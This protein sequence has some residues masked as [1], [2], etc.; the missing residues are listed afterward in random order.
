MAEAGSEVPKSHAK[1]RTGSVAL[2]DHLCGFR[3]CSHTAHLAGAASS[4][5]RFP[6]T[7]GKP[8]GLSLALSLSKESVGSDSKILPEA[9]QTPK[10]PQGRGASTIPQVA[11][12]R[13]DGWSVKG[14]SGELRSTQP[15]GAERL[16][17][18]P[19]GF[20]LSRLGIRIPSASPTPGWSTTHVILCEN[21]PD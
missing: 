16:P 21:A 20:L 18:P 5:F 13:E 17:P 1:L 19:L 6:S 3:S 9:R 4:G 8:P 15:R 2:R 10:S 12:S 7:E 14:S 11:E